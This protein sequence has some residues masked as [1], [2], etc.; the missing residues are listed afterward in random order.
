MFAWGGQHALDNTPTSTPSQYAMAA[1][2]PTPPM[3][4][5]A[6]FAEVDED[7]PI[8]DVQDMPPHTNTIASTQQATVV[9]ATRVAG[10][11]TDPQATGDDVLGITNG[12]DSHDMAVT[13]GA[14]PPAS[15]L[16]DILVQQHHEVGLGNQSSSSSA[17]G[18]MVSSIFA[19]TEPSVAPATATATTTMIA[20]VGGLMPHSSVG[21]EERVGGEHGQAAVLSTLAAGDTKGGTTTMT[22]E[23]AALRKDLITAETAKQQGV[24][25]SLREEHAGKRGRYK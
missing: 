23:A 9:Q 17:A 10:A 8:I 21:Q 7:E 20:E 2:A 18:P 16:G 19:S 4:G 14:A 24:L 3:A 11:A 5:L 6:P 12:I 13:A 25:Q 22:P 1:G 15:I